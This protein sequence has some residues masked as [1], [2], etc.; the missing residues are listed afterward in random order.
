MLDLDSI[1]Y[2]QPMGETTFKMVSPG[3]IGDVPGRFY[4]I[5]DVGRTLYIMRIFASGENAAAEKRFIEFLLKRPDSENFPHVFEMK[6]LTGDGRDYYLLPAPDNQVMFPDYTPDTLEF[7]CRCQK[8]ILPREVYETAESM[9][10]VLDILHKENFAWNRFKATDMAFCA[11]HF[12]VMN[13][14]G[15]TEAGTDAEN[16]FREDYRCLFNLLYHVWTGFAPE[17]YP[18]VPAKIPSA[19]MAAMTS[20]HDIAYG[21]DSASDIGQAMSDVLKRSRAAY[22][23]REEIAVRRLTLLIVIVFCIVAAIWLHHVL[24]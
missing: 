15:I 5:Q 7:R 19:G 23:L 16:G 18:K 3:G 14:S 8:G 2:V 10:A 17:E 20:L 4:L 9:L 1:G 21:N 24:Q 11:G 22:F 12:R 6:E 13:W